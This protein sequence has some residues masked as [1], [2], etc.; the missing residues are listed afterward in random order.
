MFALLLLTVG[1]VPAA[2]AQVGRVE[3]HVEVGEQ[4]VGP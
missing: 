1:F 2:H 4:R 3:G